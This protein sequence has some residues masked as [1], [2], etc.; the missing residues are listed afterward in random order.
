MP[1]KACLDNDRVPLIQH[2]GVFNTLGPLE[3]TFAYGIRSRWC[4]ALEEQSSQ[5]MITICCYKWW[6]V[7]STY[8]IL[9]IQRM[10]GKC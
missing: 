1:K 5:K 2:N 4:R 7:S 8:T 10:N 3:K 6:V 9:L